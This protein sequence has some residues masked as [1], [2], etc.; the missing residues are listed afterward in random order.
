[1]LQGLLPSR[2]IVYRGHNAVNIA[3]FGSA[4]AIGA[5]LTAHPAHTELF[6]VFVALGLVFGV[7]LIVPIGGADMPTVISLLN[8]Y[9]GLS[10]S[11]MGFVLDNKLLI[12]AGA[13]DG[14]SG[15]ILSVIMCRAMNRSFTNVLFG[16]FGQVKPTAGAAEERPV[17]STGPEEAASILDSARSVIVVPGYGLA[18]GP[19]QHKLR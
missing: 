6:P 7:L 16:G 5:Y 18:V 17:R 3:L 12:I 13:L 8:T 1:K 19:A 10:A 14:S 9:A 4:V 15:F 11:A 2:P